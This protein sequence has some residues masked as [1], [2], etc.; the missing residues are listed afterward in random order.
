MSTDPAFEPFHIENLTLPAAEFPV[1]EFSLRCA[2]F[3]RC[4]GDCYMQID[5]DVCEDNSPYLCGNTVCP[6]HTR[7]AGLRCYSEH[8]LSPSAAFEG[9]PGYVLFLQMERFDLKP[10]AEPLAA[11]A[12]RDEPG[13]GEVPGVHLGGGLHA[14]GGDYDALREKC[15]WLG[16]PRSPWKKGDAIAPQL[17]YIPKGCAGEQAV[18]IALEQNEQGVW[19]PPARVVDMLEQS[20]EGETATTAETTPT[21]PPEE[22]RRRRQREFPDTAGIPHEDGFSQE[23]MVEAIR[24][25]FADQANWNLRS[26]QVHLDFAIEDEAG[27]TGQRGRDRDAYRRE[28]EELGLEDVD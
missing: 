21:P 16:A 13:E 8:G 5:A 22:P 15:R 9:P 3:P 24:R 28:A 20:H 12:L 26:I 18:A 19:L 27:T 11:P 4:G 6:G 7:S 17:G 1:D 10:D 14:I 2:H 25:S 23:D